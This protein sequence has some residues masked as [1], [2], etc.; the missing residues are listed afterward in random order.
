MKFYKNTELPK[1]EKPSPSLSVDVF[2][3]NTYGE[4]DT[5]YYNFKEK[6]WYSYRN[7]DNIYHD[8]VWWYPTSDI[9][10]QFN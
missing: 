5:L 9:D 10:E 2:T 8:F 1:R 6:V 3:F 4:I 7:R